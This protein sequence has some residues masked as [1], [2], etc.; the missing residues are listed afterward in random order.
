MTSGS[1]GHGMRSESFYYGLRMLCGIIFHRVSTFS[2]KSI[3]V[4][5]GN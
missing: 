3:E 4:M 5:G 1:G 2:L